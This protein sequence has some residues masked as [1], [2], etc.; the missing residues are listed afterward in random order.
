MRE[1]SLKPSEA[2][3]LLRKPGSRLILT[4]TARGREFYV[5]P[6][7]KVTER[8]AKKILGLR[9]LR[10]IDPGLWLETAQ[11]W[12]LT[13]SEKKEQSHASER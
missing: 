1:K 3:R 2:I 6:G 7:G 13:P 9:A 10:P 8:A 12:A 11:S 5:V 4:N